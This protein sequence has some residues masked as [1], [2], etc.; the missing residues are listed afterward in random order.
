MPDY[1][2]VNKHHVQT[3]DGDNYYY[4]VYASYIVFNFNRVSIFTKIACSAYLYVCTYSNSCPATSGSK[5]PQ[6][7]PNRTP[8]KCVLRSATRFW[9]NLVQFRDNQIFINNDVRSRTFHLTVFRFQCRQLLLQK[10]SIPATLVGMN[11]PR[12]KNILA[13]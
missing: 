8:V 7:V 4:R 3:Q 1:T 12:A 10:Y 5:L 9:A 13:V 2:I 6:S 11:Y